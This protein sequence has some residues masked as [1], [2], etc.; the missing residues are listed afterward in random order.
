MN[1][2]I[3]L[4]DGSGTQALPVAKALYQNGYT[5]YSLCA[6]KYSYGYYTRY[7]N[8]RQLIPPMPEAALR[9]YFMGYIKKNRI[10]LVIPLSDRTARILSRHKEEFSGLTRFIVSDYG[11]FRS[12]FEKNRLMNIC[13]QL[14]VAHPYT[15]DLAGEPPFILSGMVFPAIIKPNIT[16]GAR[17]MVVVQDE[18][19]FISVYPSIYRMY[20]R[21]HLQQY[22][23]G[24]ARQLNVHLYV[25]STGRLLA[26]SMAWK[27]RFY[28][29]KAGSSACCISLERQ[30]DIIGQCHKVLRHIGYA[31]FA[32]FDLIEDPANATMNIMEINPRFPAN[33]GVSIASGIDYANLMVDDILGNPLREY[34]YRP[35]KTLRHTGLDFLWF[36]SSHHRLAARPNWFHW[37]G[38]NIHYQDFNVADPLAFIMGTYGN[39]QKQLNPSFRKQK[40]GVQ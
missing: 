38:P 31:G 26:S 17:G 18:N 7:V 9:E 19:E 10:D 39:L 13:R 25:G 20:G 34:K 14:E 8:H 16:T 15:I 21:C 28:P 40:A 2:R 23:A 30:E 4:L 33:I 24:G 22:I 35:G 11:A 29:V 5:V 1:R 32:S 6:E 3:L 36:C 37:F 27:A 12:A